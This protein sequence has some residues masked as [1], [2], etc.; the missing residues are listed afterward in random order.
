M[1]VSGIAS[2]DNLEFSATGSSSSNFGYNCY[3]SPLEIL[4]RRCDEAGGCNLADCTGQ[5]DGTP[6]EAGPCRVEE[7]CQAG[8]CTG[9]LKCPACTT[10]DGTDGACDVAPRPDCHTTADADS[11]RLQFVDKYDSS[12]DSLRWSWMHGEAFDADA[13]N[14]MTASDLSLCVFFRYG[15][16]GVYATGITLDT[17]CANAPCWNGGDGRYHYRNDAASSPLTSISIRSGDAGQSRIQV[18]GKGELLSNVLDSLPDFASYPITEP[19][20]TQLQSSAGACFEA[21]F[22]ASGVTRNVTGVFKASGGTLD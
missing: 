11:S 13:M 18:K 14:P 16:D 17:P 20:V 19:L 10:C 4:A 3:S 21:R 1:N 22:D 9:S 8:A 6:C 7:F 5:P 12:K 15:L 2:L